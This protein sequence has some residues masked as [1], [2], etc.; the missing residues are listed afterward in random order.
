MNAKRLRKKQEIRSMPSNREKL[1]LLE[2]DKRLKAKRASKAK[3]AVYMRILGGVMMV[4]TVYIWYGKRHVVPM[5]SLAIIGG[6][7]L[8]GILKVV[9]PGG[10]DSSNKV[11]KIM[12]IV[13]TSVIM[14][15]MIN[16]SAFGFAIML[17]FSLTSAI[18]LFGV[19]KSFPDSKAQS[20][21]GEKGG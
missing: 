11:Q 7:F 12:F 21:S 3:E 17:F 4:F 20:S 14:S 15:L 1:N 10:L 13:V 8:A 2:H 19:M 16:Q 9:Y 6:V 18:Y 5:S